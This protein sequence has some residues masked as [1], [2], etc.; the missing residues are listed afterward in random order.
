MSDGTK[1]VHFLVSSCSKKSIKITQASCSSYSETQERLQDITR[2]SQASA[3]ETVRSRN[4]TASPADRAICGKGVR[5]SQPHWTCREGHNPSALL[6][7]SFD[8]K[9]PR[10]GTSHLNVTEGPHSALPKSFSSC[11]QGWGFWTR[12]N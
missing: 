9:K 3:G 5:C 8:T 2:A 6:D 1:R 12:L 4:G 11:A 7:C 10:P